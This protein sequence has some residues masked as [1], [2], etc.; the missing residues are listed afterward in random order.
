M[1]ISNIYPLTQDTPDLQLQRLRLIRS[2]D[3]NQE[4][5]I[6]IKKQLEL[7][8]IGESKEERDDGNTHEIL[9][10]QLSIACENLDGI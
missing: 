6:T 4:V 1:T 5:Y 8:K 9:S 3:V 7:A 10:R 2:V